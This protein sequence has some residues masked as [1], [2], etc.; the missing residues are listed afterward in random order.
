[1]NY[2]LLTDYKYYD[3]LNKN[4]FQVIHRVSDRVKSL[5]IVLNILEYVTDAD[6]YMYLNKWCKIHM[7]PGMATTKTL[8]VSNDIICLS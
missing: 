3:K 7:K 2:S 8:D 4:H 6:D 1:M 5:P